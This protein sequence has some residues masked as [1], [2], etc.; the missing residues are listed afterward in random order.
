[1][2]IIVIAM[3]VVAMAFSCNP[4]EIKAYVLDEP[5]IQDCQ[6]I[7]AE[8]VALIAC[9]TKPIFKRS[10]REAFELKLSTSLKEKFTLKKVY[11]SYDLKIFHGLTKFEQMPKEK[12]QKFID[13]FFPL[14]AAKMQSNSNM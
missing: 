10:D 13:K 12:Q 2:N 8:D 9:I 4:V 5:L 6:I 3:C 14:I 1:M 7:V 11:I